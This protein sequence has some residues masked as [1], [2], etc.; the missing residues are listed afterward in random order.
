[1]R[2]PT[3]GGPTTLDCLVNGGGGERLFFVHCTGLL[4]P[5]IGVVGGFR[6]CTERPMGDLS[7]TPEGARD[8]FRKRKMVAIP[9]DPS[10][11]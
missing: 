7:E 4:A 8:N 6:T 2:C 1:M 5:T 10:A 3:C 11:N 9:P